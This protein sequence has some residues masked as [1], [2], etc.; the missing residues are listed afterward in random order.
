MKRNY[1]KNI[2]KGYL[3]VKDAKGGKIRSFDNREVFIYG[4][5]SKKGECQ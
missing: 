3:D 1:Q 5:V 4:L 2:P